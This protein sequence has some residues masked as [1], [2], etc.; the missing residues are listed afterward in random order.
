MIWL[1]EYDLAYGTSTVKSRG[2]IGSIITNYFINGGADLRLLL[3]PTQSYLFLHDLVI[4]SLRVC[5]VL[6]E[7][8]A[9]YSILTLTL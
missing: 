6:I 1:M 9:L 2:D 5:L 4:T 3:K 7:I 8:E